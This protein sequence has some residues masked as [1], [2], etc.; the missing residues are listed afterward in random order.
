MDDSELNKLTEPELELLAEFLNS[1][2]DRDLQTVASVLTTP[3]FGS[4]NTFGAGLSDVLHY[5]STSITNIDRQV[6]RFDEMRRGLQQILS[7]TPPDK[8]LPE[9]AK[10]T[11]EELQG[12]A[13]KSELTSFYSQAG[14][15]I[16]EFSTE[17]IFE[18][19]VDDERRSNRVKTDLENQSQYE[20]EWL[21]WVT[22]ILNNEDKDNLR[23]TYRKRNELVHGGQLD[24]M[25]FEEIADEISQ[26][27]AAVN[28][29]HEKTYGL[30]ME[31]RIS[32]ITLG[33][34][35]NY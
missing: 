23:D 17:L 32:E 19:I 16:E 3:E 27:W 8:E 26:A 15:L 10:L 14:I 31:H 28:I 1:T 5:I 7:Q 11:P 29:L 6:M 4:N 24:S 30:E 12:V 2:Q 18:E 25:I 9:N 20:R 33:N 35:F 13:I 22:G 21:L 34:D